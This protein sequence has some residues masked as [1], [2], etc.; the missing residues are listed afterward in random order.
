MCFFSCFRILWVSPGLNWYIC[1]YP[2]WLSAKVSIIRLDYLKLLALLPSQFIK[3]TLLYQQ[4]KSLVSKFK[5]SQASY[6]CRRVLEA[7]KVAKILIKQESLSLLR[8]VTLR[9][10]GNTLISFPS[11]CKSAIPSLSQL[12]FSSLSAISKILAKFVDDRLVNQLEKCCLFIDFQYGF[13][14]SHSIS[15][16]QTVVS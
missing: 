8:N 4:S 14:H 2:S 9:T 5:F 11:K 16:V 15:D 3:I 7:A 12:A 1:I 10:F 6:C 13:K